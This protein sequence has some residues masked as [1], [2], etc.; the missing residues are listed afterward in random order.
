MWW[1]NVSYNDYEETAEHAC[2]CPAGCVYSCNMATYYE[3]CHP[4]HSLRQVQS[5]KDKITSQS[6][7]AHAVLLPSH[8][9]Q[10]LRG[11]VTIKVNMQVR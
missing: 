6:H 5:L 9:G 2:T 7:A 4:T 1:G 10:N 8:V 11:L 3:T